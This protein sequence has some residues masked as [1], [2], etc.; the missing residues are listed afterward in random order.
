MKFGMKLARKGSV[1]N[2]ESVVEY[3][4]SESKLSVTSALARDSVSAYD[5]RRF[6]EIRL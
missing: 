1:K 2:L 5:I 3:K 6:S 4:R